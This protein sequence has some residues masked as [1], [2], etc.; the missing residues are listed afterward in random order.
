MVIALRRNG[1]QNVMIAMIFAVLAPNIE[2]VFL[3][4]SNR[5]KDE[6]F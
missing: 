4:S 6:N 2:E 1:P 3:S 5:L